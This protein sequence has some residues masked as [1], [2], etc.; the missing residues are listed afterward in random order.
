MMKKILCFIT[1][2]A[3]LLAAAIPANAAQLSTLTID[4]NN[5]THKVSPT[6]YGAFIEDISFAGDGGLVANLVNN[7]S[8]EDTD[9]PDNA[10]AFGGITP[11]ISTDDA[12]NTANRTYE[13]LTVDG[14]GVAENLGYTEIYDYKTYDYDDGTAKKADMGFEEG[15]DYDFSCY[16]KNVD[17]DGTISV[18]LN[19]KSNSGSVVQMG[20]DGVSNSSWSKLTATL[21]SKGTEDGSLAIVFDGKG[22]IKL[23]FVSLVPQNSHGY[24]NSEWKH[25]TLRADLYEALKNLNPSFIRFPGGCFAEG[26][27]LDN[28]Y[29]WKHTIGEPVQRKQST[30]IWTDPNNGRYYI[31]TNSLGYHEYFQLCED[32]GAKAVPVVNAGITCQGRNG[33]GDLLI[34]K[35]KASMSDSEWHAYLIGER[36]YDEKDEEGIKNYTDYIDSLG[37]KSDED[38]EA[39]LDEIALRPGTAEFKNYVQDILD[40]VEYANADSNTSYWGALRAANGHAEPFDIEYLAIGNENWGDLYFRNLK[41]IYKAVHKKYPKLKII[42]SVGAASEGTDFE[43]AWANIN[44]NYGKTFADEHYY[45]SDNWLLENVHRYDSYDRDGAGVVLGEYGAHSEGYG[46]MITKSNMRTATAVGAYMTGLERNSDIVKMS[47]M[48]PTFA[49][50][51][52]NAWDYNLIWFDS[53]DVALTPDYYTQMI[54]ANNIGTKYIEPTSANVGENINYS[55]TVDEGKEIMYIKLVNTGGREHINLVTGEANAASMLTLSNKYKSASNEIGKQRVAPKEEEL[56]ITKEAGAIDCTLDANSVNVIRVAYGNNQGD[57]FYHIPDTVNTETKA[58]MP[59]T[60]LAAIII[61]PLCLV[62]GTVAGYL[63]YIKILSKRKEE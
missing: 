39:K 7:G 40:L 22:T 63:I 53:H 41:A 55:V 34:A 10:W 21:K 60:A 4:K 26:N 28:L 8:F 49:K 35:R 17:F 31:N 30:N 45:S 54:F 57:N 36:G 25:V 61:L 42:T 11:V 47:A 20:T 62:G 13:T 16:V 50:V 32:L 3:M 44:R 2:L 27:S 12:M 9:K 33:Y 56:E 29:N 46:T 6:L 37:V 43:N 38:F 15:V 24:G 23:D 1:A 19:S 58:Y 51:N 18:Y 59:A 5:T 48:A 14:R 52:A